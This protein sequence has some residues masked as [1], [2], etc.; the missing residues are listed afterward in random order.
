MK[1]T[2][3]THIKR[4]LIAASVALAIPLSAVAFSGHGDHAGC[5]MEAHG[6][7]GHHMMGGNMMPPHLRALNLTEAQQDK[8][9]EI[10]HAQAPV[11]RDKAKALRK[12]ETDL[13][14]LTS[15]PDY[16]EA[17][18]RAL[19]DE[20]A[21]AMSEMTLARAKADRQVFEVLTPEQRKQ[22]AE[23]KPTERGPRGRGDGPRGAAADAAKPAGR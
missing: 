22:S 23:T 5:G 11:M 4:F 21:K 6:G 3:N 14:A 10:M 18:A 15:A 12:A 9:F 1:T 2:P 16:S 13:R 8:V 7:P 19:A 20:A 17:K